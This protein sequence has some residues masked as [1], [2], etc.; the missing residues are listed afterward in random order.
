ML[1]FLISTLD[2]WLLVILLINDVESPILTYKATLLLWY[3][4]FG[5]KRWSYTRDFTV[6]VFEVNQTKFCELDARV[7]SVFSASCAATRRVWRS[8][9]QSGAPHVTTRVSS[10]WPIRGRSPPSGKP[11]EYRRHRVAW[12]RSLRGTTRGR[13]LP[14]VV[15][16]RRSTCSIWVTQYTLAWLG[17][18]GKARPVWHRPGGKGQGASFT[19]DKPRVASVESPCCTWPVAEYALTW[20]GKRRKVRPVWNRPDHICTQQLVTLGDNEAP[21]W[22]ATR[23]DVAVVVS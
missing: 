8:L 12:Q 2:S 19:Q 23:G 10:R 9:L 20:R 5:I 21:H 17:M 4:F 22:H 11:R 1:H 14:G 7:G 15:N 6:N 18:R 13:W 16:M 3:Q